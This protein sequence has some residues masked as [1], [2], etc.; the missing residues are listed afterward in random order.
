MDE[1]LGVEQVADYLGF[2]P[3]TVRTWL[4]QGRFAGAVGIRSA[5]GR[6]PLAAVEAVAAGRDPEGGASR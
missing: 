3:E 6:V 5:V 1:L 4:R 2:Q